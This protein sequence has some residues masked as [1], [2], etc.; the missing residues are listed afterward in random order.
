MSIRVFFRA[1]FQLR[2]SCVSVA[3]QLRFSY[4]SAHSNFFET[5]FFLGPKMS[6]FLKVKLLV[7]LFILCFSCVSAK[8]GCSPSEDKGFSLGWGG[9]KNTCILGV[10][11]DVKNISTY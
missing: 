11:F 1:A 10:F 4:V 8:T 6:A 9:A 2:F 7:K 3:F 5:S